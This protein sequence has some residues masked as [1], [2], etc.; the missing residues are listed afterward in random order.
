MMKRKKQ[1][2]S[3]PVSIE[4]KQAIKRVF[5]TEDGTTLLAFLQQ[6]AR[7][8]APTYAMGKKHED[9]VHHGARKALV[10]EVL[11]ILKG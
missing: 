5:D 4:M 10:R 9:M 11:D 1:E 8:D 7:F 2:D 6:Q 3:H